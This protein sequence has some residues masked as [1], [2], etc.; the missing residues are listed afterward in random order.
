MLL[1]LGAC[2]AGAG[3]TV[4]PIGDVEI[5]NFREGFSQWLVIRHPPDGVTNVVSRRKVVER[6]TSCERIGNQRINP[7][8]SAISYKHRACLRAQHHDVT[9][10]I[11]FF[12]APSTLV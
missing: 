5:R 12:V 10:A 4:M 11:V 1:Q 8:R 3:G 9:R 2:A 7:R 6:P